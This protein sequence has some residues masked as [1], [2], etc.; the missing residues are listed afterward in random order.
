M[1]RLGRDQCNGWYRHVVLVT[2][3]S[4]GIGKIC[5]EYLAHRHNSASIVSWA[6]STV[7]EGWIFS[8]ASRDVAQIALA[9]SALAQTCAAGESFN[10]HFVQALA[11][12]AGRP[13][14]GLVQ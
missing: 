11:L 7:S 13:A 6:E 8:P 4:S 3:A 1:R 10:R 14:K 9:E 2:G 5:G 12:F